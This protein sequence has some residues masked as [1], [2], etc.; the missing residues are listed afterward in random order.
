MTIK[1]M[2][3]VPTQMAILAL[4]VLGMTP[5]SSPPN[6]ERP[7]GAAI[8]DRFIEVTGG[9]SAYDKL[10]NRVCHN[11]I[12]HV[13][14]G[15]E[16]KAVIYTARPNKRFV[17]I[18]SEAMGDIENGTDGNVVWYL[19]SGGDP[20]V[21]TGGAREAQLSDLAFDRMDNWRAYY[22]SA[23]LVKELDIEG[24]HCYEVLLT[25]NVGPAETHYYDRGSGLLVKARKTRPSSFMAT[26]VFDISLSDYK[27]VDGVRLP[28][29]VHQKFDQC[30]SPREMIFVTERIEH[31]VDLPSD[32]FTP[33]N[34][35]MAAATVESIGGL[36]K[37]LVGGEEKTPPAPCGAKSTES[38]ERHEDNKDK[39]QS[40]K[41]CCGGS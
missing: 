30:G 17:H 36:V 29:K 7:T 16:D 24:E 32:R 4:A 38:E 31:N 28:H 25:P 33:P 10:H 13:G 21:E 11:R 37:S 39:A 9:K 18:E 41:P 23:E 27:L 22:K 2:T 35:A 8:V 12:V 20:L 14:M 3:W 6:A 34:S 1:A 19:P 40:K 15:F 26:I 5:D